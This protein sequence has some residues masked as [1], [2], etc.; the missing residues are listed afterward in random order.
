[1][2]LFSRI[3]S[4]MGISAGPLVPRDGM[5][6][7]YDFSTAK[8]FRGQPT[9]NFYTN[10]HFSG[11]TGVTQESG[12]NPTNTVIALP[13][14]GASPYVL[15]QSMGSA[16]TEYQINL[17]TELASSTTY[18]MSGWYAE[19]SDYSCADGSR[20][21]HSRAF[22]TSG[23]HVA[24]GLGIG[25]VLET[26]FVGGLLWKYCFTTITTP[27]DYNNNFNWYLGYGNNSYTGKRYY[28]NLQMESGTYP[29]AF[30]NG[31]RGT[32]VAAGGGVIDLSGTSNNGQLVN[33]PTASASFG[34]M[35]M[36]DGVDD[37]IRASSISATSVS[38]A[39]WV[40]SSSWST[41]TH[42]MIVA[43]GIN[44]E[45]ILWKSDDAGND[46]KF[47][48]RASNSSTLYSTTTAQNNVW[49]H[50]MGTI[51]AAGMRL[52]VNGVLEASTSTTAVPSGSLDIC[53]GAGISGG[54]PANFLA[55]SVRGVQ[56]WGRQLSATEVLQNYNSS[57]VTLLE[58]TT[59]V[60]SNL[61]LH[62]DAS[63]RDSYRG[64]GTAWRDLSG[65]GN[66]F[67]LVNGVR[68]NS[69]K[70][71]SLS[72]DGTNDYAISD[73]NLNLTT[74]DYVVLDVWFR[75]N[76]TSTTAMLVEHT[77]SWNGNTGGWGVAINTNGNVDSPGSVHTNHNTEVARNY[78][79]AMGT[80]WN[81]Q[82]NIFSKISDST[83][84]LAY[85]NGSLVAFDSGPGYGTTTVTTAGGSFPNDKLYIG[86]RGGS[87]LFFNGSISSVKIY[88][89]K[90]TAQEVSTNFNSARTRF[91]G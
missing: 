13:N 43:K 17:T 77:T 18:C 65:F 85:C 42:P 4:L 36:F 11:G 6:L 62:L 60:T 37:H 25:T 89:V 69:E 40:R 28:T 56:V 9:T 49:Y 91:L 31:T 76:T 2:G 47:G 63:N 61:I 74:Y 15:E 67:T 35:V 86:S 50:L 53:V 79:F 57:R 70:G 51:G 78:L 41:Q 52:Y 24:L 84:R 12:S 48:W 66:H 58:R 3:Y 64:T 10:G 80:F 33:G 38:V 75:S 8:S 34:G 16:F 44:V 27:S 73:N 46:E 32:T 87:T 88:G 39:A 55:G 20:M 14:P 23:N 90:L 81:N 19:S 45:W 21:F 72:F 22:S 59:P 7:W 82:V 54:N 1:M 30:V 83:G 71:G 26:R 5:L 68:Y 29:R